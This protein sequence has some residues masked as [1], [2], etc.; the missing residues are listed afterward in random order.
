MLIAPILSA[1]DTNLSRKDSS[2][3]FK[4]EAGFAPATAQLRHAFLARPRHAKRGQKPNQET[5]PKP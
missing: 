4:V 2:F 1:T 3:Y 5:Q